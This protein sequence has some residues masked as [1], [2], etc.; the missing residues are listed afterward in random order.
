MES[1]KFERDIKPM[2]TKEHLI[3]EA[4]QEKLGEQIVRIDLRE[5][6]TRPADA[7]I[8]CHGHNERQV[9]AL[10][11]EVIFRVKKQ[12]H[13]LPLHVEG[14]PAGRWV[15]IDY[16]DVM[17]HIFKDE[18]VREHYDLEGLWHDGEISTF[19]PMAASN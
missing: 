16:F 19:E 14:L 8:I 6:Q 1:F 2:N 3:I 4:L 17:V 11:D 15:V 10:A 13:E 12:A 18:A 5:V 9:Q 7:F